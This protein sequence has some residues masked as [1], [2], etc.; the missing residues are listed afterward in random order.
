MAAFVYLCRL[1]M[2]NV[3]FFLLL[4]TPVLKTF[5]QQDSSVSD[6]IDVRVQFQ[7]QVRQLV[8]YLN[9]GNENAASRMFKDVSAAMDGFIKTTQA[10]ADTATGSNKKVLREKLNNQLQLMMQFQ[11]FKPNLIRNRASIHT[12]SDQFVKTLYP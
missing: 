9:E 8:S 2:R 12:W 3:I 5:A 7:S 11:S 4:L 1:L 6:S 10:A